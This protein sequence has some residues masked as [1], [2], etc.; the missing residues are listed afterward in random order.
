ML[1]STPKITKRGNNSSILIQSNHVAKSCF[2]EHF[3]IPQYIGFLCQLWYKAS[4]PLSHPFNCLRQ[5][6]YNNFPAFI[7]SDDFDCLVDMDWQLK[8]TK[9]V[10]HIGPCFIKTKVKPTCTPVPCSGSFWDRRWCR[11]YCWCRGC[12]RWL[13]FF[14]GWGDKWIICFLGG[15]SGSACL[16]RDTIFCRNMSRHT[17][18]GRPAAR[19]ETMAL[20]NQAY[21]MVESVYNQWKT[22]HKGCDILIYY[23]V[24]R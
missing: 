23:Y 13:F 16:W 6:L 19:L 10:L 2:C 1:D 17:L 15:T 11:I 5:Y 4:I 18:M 20:M 21:F 3:I 12:W 7:I 8:R 9:G 22:H 24:P 14:L